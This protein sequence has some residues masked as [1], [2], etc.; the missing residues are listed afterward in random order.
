MFTDIKLHI[1]LK[2][3]LNMIGLNAYMLIDLKIS[4]E[5]LIIMSICQM[6]ARIFVKI[7]K[8]AAVP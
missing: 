4:E 1:V 2:K 6:I 7:K 3:M 5:H 8:M